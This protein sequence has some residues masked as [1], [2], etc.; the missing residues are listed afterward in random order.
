VSN[1]ELNFG[2]PQDERKPRI[3]P[4]TVVADAAANAAARRA[5][6]AAAGI[7]VHVAALDWQGISDE[8]NAH[9]YAIIP[10]LLT[11][12]ECA[13]MA[14]HYAHPQLF[15][16]RVVMSQH[17]FGSGE[18]Q[19]FR[20]PLP[21]MISALRNALY[22]PLA[23]IANRWHELMDLPDRFPADH[24]DFLARCHAAGQQR[25][26][27]LLLEYKAGDYNCLHQDLY[28]EH[29]FPLQ[30]AV[31][32]NQP[33]K[34]FEGGEFVLTEQRP[35]MQ[36]R[37]EVVPLKRGDMVIFAVNHRPV[38]GTRGIYRVNLRHGVSRLRSGSRHTLGIIF[39]DAN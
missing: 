18:Y 10:G 11:A 5:V 33:G 1:G 21:S 25:P 22:G 34:D 12:D 28:G 2:D 37:V 15:R 20:Y 7:A 36:S 38:Q 16:S 3:V 14:A 26:T 32:L 23:A 19:Y 24:A 17:G 6:G 31:L 27:P 9:G 35:R 30:A 8:L 29:V 4:P 13:D 39:H